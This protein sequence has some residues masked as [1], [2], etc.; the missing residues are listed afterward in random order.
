[1]SKLKCCFKILIGFLLLMKISI[2]Q[3][4]IKPATVIAVPNPTGTTATPNKP[5]DYSAGILV[6]Y[7]RTWQPQQPT[8]DELYVTSSSRTVD[9]VNVSTQYFDGLGRPLQTVGWQT[10]PGKQDIVAPMVYDDFGR[11]QYKYLSYMSPTASAAGKQGQFKINPFTEQSNFYTNTYKTEQPAF[12]NETFFYNK[13]NFEPSPLNR[14]DQNFA[15]GNSWVGSEGGA[16]EKKVSMQYLVNISTDAVRIW[17]IAFTTPIADNVNIPYSNTTDIYNPGELYKNV[18]MDEAGNAVVEYKDKEGH[19]ILKKVQ[20]GTVPADFSGYNNFLCT[21]YIY[22]EMGDLRFV[23][24][25][26]AVA[27][28]AVANSWVLSQI[29]VN[30]LCFRYEYDYRQRMIA[31]KVPG[32]DWVVMVY[33]TRDRLVFLQDGN[34]RLKNQWMT[35]IYDDLNRPVQTG[36]SVYTATVSTFSATRDNLQN[37]VNSLTVSSSPVPTSGTNVSNIAIDL[38][39]SSREANNLSYQASNSII[40]QDGFTSAPLDSFTAS[41]I[42]ASNVTFSNTQTVN[43]NPTTISGITYIPLTITNYD[44]YTNTGKN[45]DVTNNG[46]LDQGTAIYAD[47]PPVGKILAV[48]GMVTSTR[49]RVLENPNNLSAG[50][51]L[52]TV[53]FYDSKGIPSQVQSDNYKGGTDI[54]TSRYDFLGKT[55]SS[56]SVHNNPVGNESNLRVKTNMDYD[57]I[58][59]LKETRK[60]INDDST[61]KR[62]IADEVYDALGQLKTKKLGQQTDPTTSLPIANFLENQDFAYNIRGWLKGINWNY[63]AASGPTT[64]QI[65]LPSNKWFSMDLSYDWGFTSTANQ[66][67]GNIS[68]MRWKTLGDGQ[69][70]AYGFSYDAV[71]RITKG[72]FTENVNSTTWD[73]SAGIDFTMQGITYDENG[74]IKTMQQNGLKITSAGLSSPAID[75]LTYTYNGTNQVSNKLLAVTESPAI[76]TTNNMLGDFTDKNAGLND[77]TYD[78]NGNLTSDQNKKIT[79]ILYNHLNLPWQVSI[80]NDDGTAKGTITYIYDAAGNKLEKRTSE[81]ASATNNKYAKQTYTAYI[82]G[83][84]YENNVLQF[85]GQEEGRI[86]PKRDPNGVFL[87]YVYDYFLKD[88]LGNARMVLTD[89]HRTDPYPAATMETANAA[90]ENTFYSNI[91]ATRYTPLPP[92]YPVD[93][94]TSPNNAVAKVTAAAGGIKVGPSIL[95]KVMAG[96]KFNLRVSSWYNTYSVPPGSTVSPLTDIATA[97][98]NGVPGVSGGKVAAGQLSGT[99]LNPS[100]TSFLTT[101]DLSTVTNRPKAYVNWVLFDDRFNYVNSSSGAEQVP[102]ESYFNNAG[103]PK[104]FVHIRANMPIDKNGY[105]YVYVSNETQ[106]IPVY[107][108]N[109]QVTQIRGPLL[110][111]TH[112]YPFGLTMSG[113]SSQ[114]AKG[115]DYAE[116]KKGFNGNELQSKEFSDLSGLAWYDFNARTYDPQIGRF[117]QIDPTPDEA[118]QES[119]TPYHFSGNNPIRYNDPDGKCPWCLIPIIIGLLLTPEPANP[120]SSLP[121]GNRTQAATDSWNN[122]LH[123]RDVM[124]ATSLLSG[125]AKMAVNVIDNTYTRINKRGEEIKSL[126]NENKQLE[127]SNKTYEKRIEEHQQKLEEYKKDPEKFDNKK[128]LEGKTPEQRQ[129]IIDGRVKKLENEI[130]KFENN[131]DKN[132]QQIK[133]NQQQINNR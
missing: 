124:I 14:I 94:Y 92:G 131:V 42:T 12:T 32:A 115:T 7:I 102:A 118:G 34:M 57:H 68:G 56:Y 84:V 54:V 108:D 107:F 51:W 120:P 41:I 53:T 117:I 82:E 21:Y 129:Q 38:I 25:P 2:S 127:K 59:R 3:A 130:K 114:A 28:M 96:D 36:M 55:V 81:A 87:D 133:N 95:L 27:P 16:A 105:L 61:R 109:L 132:N 39:I 116:N 19:V 10:S 4:Q 46:K 78:V 88:H 30:E 69:E 23:I 37:A 33:D 98:T 72:N 125:G 110:E 67:N 50:N 128:V 43:T 40:F 48:K 112:Y 29:T 58:G 74:N 22:D 99:T 44:D 97:L 73:V 90:V 75:N 106:N 104:N 83:N 113:I 111:E 93:T 60:Q 11:E 126:Q 64:S 9:E 5:A 91:D 26:K 45:Y 86:R 1:M 15:P 52:E 31:K 66:Y 79:G 24:P 123:N 101:R 80:N 77:Y 47:L 18:M 122:A 63:A 35:T 71:N 8:T 100:V 121:A 89:D 20:I 70:R 17:R 76:G 103:T 49:V 119:L 85:F 13:T 6:N 62:I 65:N